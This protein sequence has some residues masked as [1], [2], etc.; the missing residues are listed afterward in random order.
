MI[1]HL[2]EEYVSG[3]MIR[4]SEALRDSLLAGVKPETLVSEMIGAIVNEPRA[5]WLSLLARLS[6]VK[7]PYVEAKLLVALC[8]VQPMAMPA[9]VVR[10]ATPSPTV[11]PKVDDMKRPGSSKPSKLKAPGAETND[12]DWTS[13]TCKVQELNDGV[14]SQ[15]I[16]C[17]H[18]YQNGELLLYPPRKFVH[19]LLSRDNN[20]AILVQAADGVKITIAD[21]GSTSNDK[22]VD[23]TLSKISAIMGGEVKNDGGKSPF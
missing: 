20:K 4:I 22:P 13:Y 16:K 14:Y 18:E 2:L 12:F 8:G 3:D 21:V 9:R 17:D 1:A 5:E 7:E 23:E 10:A 11:E 19:T 6:E 15:L